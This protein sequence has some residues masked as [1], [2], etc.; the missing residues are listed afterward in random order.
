MGASIVLALA[1]FAAL[2]VNG[3][4]IFQHI[5]VNGADQDSLVGVRA[6]AVNNPVKDVSSPDIAC[7][8][9]LKTPVSTAVVTI[10]AR[11]KVGAWFQH[12]AGDP[13]NPITAS[14]T[15]PVMVYLAKVGNAGTASW[16]GL[17]WFKVTTEEGFDT[18]TGKWGVDTMI[19]G[20]G[21][22]S[23][24]MPS[25]VAAGQYL[26]QVELIAL[27][28]AYATGGAQFYFSCSN[29]QITGSGTKVGNATVKFPGAYTASDPGI[30]LNIYNGT[31][32]NNNLKPY[33]IP[34]PAPM[35]C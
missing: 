10:P 3:H 6:P 4:C 35:Q 26:M 8:T 9:G 30:L 11:A 13:D 19:A 22:W 24:T 1:A 28:S 29:V 14:H 16:T 12:M 7:N 27:H 23:F 5:K 17:N 34:G 18:T 2:T 15:G 25:C 20:N 33:T 32:P 31:I 21:W